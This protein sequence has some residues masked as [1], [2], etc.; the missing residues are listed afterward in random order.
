MSDEHQAYR[1]TK[2]ENN[3]GNYQ[4]AGKFLQRMHP[5]TLYRPGKREEEKG[6]RKYRKERCA[7]KEYRSKAAGNCRIII[8][9]D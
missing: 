4:Y 3:C 1:Y 2:N 7:E 9:R 6:D 8:L 5:Q